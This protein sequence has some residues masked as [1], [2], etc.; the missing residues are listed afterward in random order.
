M[1]TRLFWAWVIVLP[2]LPAGVQAQT[3]TVKLR[4][5]PDAGKGVVFRKVEKNDGT[6]K[7]TD[8]AGKVLVDEKSKDTKE[9]EYTE[10]I[11]EKGDKQPAKFKRAYDKA[12]E[13][14]G[15]ETAGLGHQRRTIVCEWKDGSYRVTAE[16]KPE[17]TPKDLDDLAEEVND[18]TLSDQLAVIQPP[19]AVKI[20]ES[21]VVDNK[22][23]AT[24]FGK[25][26]VLDAKSKAEARLVKVYEK[27]GK[28]HG[29]I[30]IDMKLVLKEIKGIKFD[31]AAPFDFKVSFDGVID[32]SGTAFTMTTGG[33][34]AG[35]G[36]YEENGK[37]FAVELSLE[38]SSKEER[39]A[40]K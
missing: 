40:E 11:L 34:L 38:T 16:G 21:W 20:D 9:E 31:P 18:S 25:S 14:K 37:K 2:V 10:T 29:V 19:K 15:G 33:K 23:I 13:T 5:N 12:A 26:T 39:S 1:R 27:N 17:L 30:E 28:Q 36:T 35:K 4:A 22:L 8:A 7:M 3:Y 24:A 6:F 32:G